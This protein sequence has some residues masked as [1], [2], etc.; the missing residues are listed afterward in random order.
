[1]LSMGWIFWI[2]VFVFAQLAC[3]FGMRNEK[4]RDGWP[5][6]ACIIAAI[7]CFLSA[8]IKIVP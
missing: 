8:I 6:A 5:I 2:L 3:Y 1:M 7:W 4:D